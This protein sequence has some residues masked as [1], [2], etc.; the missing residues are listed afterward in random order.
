MIAFNH[1]S[2]SCGSQRKC[3]SRFLLSS[4]CLLLLLILAACASS[5]AQKSKQTP[6]NSGTT[7]SCSSHSSDP[8]TLTM[9]Y[10]SEK[11]SWIENVVKDFNSR[12]ITACDG[13]ITVKATPIG[14]G[15]SMLD[16]L[17]GAAKP[18]LWSPAGTVWLTLMNAQWQA[19][20]NGQQLI[21]TGASDTPSLVTSPVVIAMWKP[22][23]EAL[24]WPKTP[25][26]WSNIAK[27]STDPNGWRTYGHPEFGQFK[28]GHTRPDSSNS[29]LDA[30]I[31]MNYAATNKV[32]GLTLDDV[33]SSTTK[34]FV[35]TV[36]SSVIHYGDSTGFFADKMFNNGPGYLSA[37]VMYENLVVSANDG[38]TYPHLAYP[39]VAI[40]PKEGT[41]YS[42]H[43][44]AILNASWVTPAK[45]AAG[46]AFRNFLLAKDQQK[47]ALQYGFRPADLGISVTAPIDGAHGVDPKQPSTSLQIPNANVVT[48]IQSNWNTQKRRVDAMLILDRSGS[49]NQSLGGTTK[50]D[51]AKAGLK[52]FVKLFNDDDK[53]GLTIFST[54]ADVLT[55]IDQL[56]PKRQKML[57]SIDGVIAEG[58]TRLFNTI[59]EQRNALQNAQSKNIK[60]LIVLTDGED[61][62]G[63]MN[64]DQLLQQVSLT[65][66]N[67]GTGVKIY[68]IAYGDGANVDAL[69][70]IANAAGGKEYAGNPQNI[71]AVYNEI[72]QFL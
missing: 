50:I 10:G 34:N 48:T 54:Q 32:R 56:G 7:I 2:R 70:K 3:S 19:K 49:M 17:S 38:K 57:D 40:Y 64:L 4:W 46:L 43:P 65:G 59:A 16:I 68:T 28:F 12:N 53:V 21:G 62:A 23:A 52:D 44:Y 30:V 39:V 66:E 42:D 15:Q 33:N 6:T 37:T 20:H 9:L 47:K 60:A 69:T 45:K 14:S 41:F 29:G 25:I 13:P 27:L 72:S 24:G 31:A 8:V 18:E 71:Q 26:G 22:Q 63:Q 51:G 58:D 1:T 11:K 36:E 67:A 5:D 61:T 35:S 55:P